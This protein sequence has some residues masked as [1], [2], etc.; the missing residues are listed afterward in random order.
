MCTW[1]LICYAVLWLDSD[2]YT[3]IHQ[4]ILHWHGG[5]LSI[6]PLPTKQP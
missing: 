1:I 5:N 3:N 6:A 2:R 4:A